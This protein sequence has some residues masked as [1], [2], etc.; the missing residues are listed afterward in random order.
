M[1]ENANVSTVDTSDWDSAIGEVSFTDD[2]DADD[3]AVETPEKQPE[4]DPP[5]A[6]TQE[7]KPAEN[8]PDDTTTEPQEQP[9]DN[10]SFKLK[11][12]G[13]EIEVTREEA[14]TLAQ[15]GKDYDRIREKYDEL[16]ATAAKNAER[17]E[18]ID[19]LAKEMGITP[20]D[21]IESAWLSFYQSKGLDA[22]TAREKAALAKEKRE[23]AREKAAKAEADKQQQDAEAA[24]Q[25]AEARKQKEFREFIAK[26]PDVKAEDIPPAVWA[27]FKAGVPLVAA[28]AMHENAGL[29]AKLA[30]LEKNA[31]NAA[32]STG[33]K[34]SAGNKTNSNDIWSQIE[35]DWRSD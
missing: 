26:R 33:S 4:A 13:E 8:N 31:S 1:D 27:D 14:V 17:D 18:S 11:Y 34:A 9:K 10:Q 7:D 2:P 30:A 22:D 20:D 12:L 19:A 6:E 23:I 35:S 25:A 21:F 16:K 5:K 29:K 32:R 15:K 28:Y 3:Y 24:K